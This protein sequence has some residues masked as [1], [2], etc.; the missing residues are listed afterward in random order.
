MTNPPSREALAG[1]MDHLGCEADDVRCRTHS[2]SLLI[3]DG[4]RLA[5][6]RAWDRAWAAHV[7]KERHAD[8]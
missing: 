3:H 8:D 6:P 1:A 4:G 5:C 7:T 2:A